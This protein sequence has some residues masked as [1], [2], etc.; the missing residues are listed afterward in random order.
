MYKIPLEN[1][2]VVVLFCFVLTVG[3]SVLLS[4]AIKMNGLFL[5]SFISE[6]FY[7][8]LGQNYIWFHFSLITCEGPLTRWWR[9]WELL[10][11]RGNSWRWTI[12]LRDKMTLQVVW[13]IA[14]ERDA[15][16]AWNQ[17]LTWRPT[18]GPRFLIS[19]TEDALENIV[20]LKPDILW[21]TLVSTSTLPSPAI[22]NGR[23]EIFLPVLIQS[24]WTVF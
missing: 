19:P 4:F 1:K 16:G 7:W 24:K 13:A 6:F 23:M 18:T 21:A 15:S 2:S 17:A 11:N 8:N 5:S 3:G 22:T 20:N 14:G 10:G 9:L 12:L